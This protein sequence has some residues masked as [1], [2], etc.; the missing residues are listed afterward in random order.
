LRDL[1]YVEA[2][3]LA[4][5][6]R[7]MAGREDHYP[8]VARELSDGRVDL[9]VTT[10]HPAA[11]AAKRATSQIPIV[12]L[13]VVD[14]VS[15]GLAARLSRPGGNLTDFS[16]EVTP[17]DPAFDRGRSCGEASPRPA[18]LCEPRQRR[19]PRCDTAGGGLV[20]G[21][22]RS[23]RRAQRRGHRRRLPGTER[24]GSRARRVPGGPCCGRIGAT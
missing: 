21:G 12:A 9:I 1:G 10:G 23:V 16:L 24:A 5:D 2:L 18:E 20:G 17:D 6:Y 13:A 19:L 15:S 3:N 8:D 14:P 11:L 4:I 7:W 22:V